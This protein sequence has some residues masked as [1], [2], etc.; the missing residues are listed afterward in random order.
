LAAIRA[1]SGVFNDAIKECY[2]MEVEGIEKNI[3]SLKSALQALLESEAGLNDL[4]ADKI[5]WAMKSII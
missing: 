5:E 1:P 2:Q 3:S 4:K